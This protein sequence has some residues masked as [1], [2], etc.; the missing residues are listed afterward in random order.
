MESAAVAVPTDFHAAPSSSRLSAPLA[1]P[2]THTGAAVANIVASWLGHTITHERPPRAY[3]P[4]WSQSSQEVR[5]ELLGCLLAAVGGAYT[6]T[7]SKIAIGSPVQA[8]ALIAMLGDRRENVAHAACRALMRLT[9]NAGAVQH[10]LT[11]D[12]A[13]AI[14]RKLGDWRPEWR[15]FAIDFFGTMVLSPLPRSVRLGLLGALS[16]PVRD[17]RQEAVTVLAAASQG[18]PGYASGLLQ[19]PHLKAIADLLGDTMLSLRATAVTL[20]TGILSTDPV[21]F[22]PQQPDHLTVLVSAT[23][24]CVV[25]KL[26]HPMRGTRLSA[27]QVLKALPAAVVAPYLGPAVLC[28][29]G[30]KA[31][32]VRKLVVELLGGLPVNVAALHL[33]GVLRK[34]LAAGGGGNKNKTEC[35]VAATEVLSRLPSSLLVPCTQAL[36]TLYSHTD[37]RVRQ[38]A[39]R[40]TGKC[41]S[42]A[43][44]PHLPL[45]AAC[46]GDPHWGVRRAAL[47]VLGGCPVDLV[48]PHLL[49][50][51]RLLDDPDEMVR[52]ACPAVLASFPP[53]EAL[54]PHLETLVTH[55]FGDTSRMVRVAAIQALGELPAAALRTH[56]LLERIVAK[57]HDESSAMRLVVLALLGRLPVDALAP[58]V[59]DVAARLEDEEE[60]VPAVRH[61]ALDLLVGLPAEL[62]APHTKRLRSLQAT[63]VDPGVCE[64]AARVLGVAVPEKQ[65]EQGKMVVV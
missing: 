58:F 56:G 31:S 61:Q 41:P 64:R 39:L 3:T 33:E 37:A 49:D 38:A 27:L 17:V 62:L 11:A 65:K 36:L 22:N 60:T 14:Q 46:L 16:D 25:T 8:S 53:S 54:L 4:S 50:M 20:L 44:A 19:V 23:L 6:W 30:D 45:V 59:C 5:V 13:A 52:E 32:C 35:Q 47:Q 15:C 2:L 18:Q 12:H 28:K 40:A 10:F 57:L 1:P 48:G 26:G 34:A 51:A 24:P 9:S 55:A 42:H 63:G 7:G 29:L 43:L 21:R